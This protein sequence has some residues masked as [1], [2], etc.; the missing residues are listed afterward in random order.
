MRPKVSSLII[1]YH[2]QSPAAMQQRVDALLANGVDHVYFYDNSQPPFDC[3]FTD[4]Y[5]GKL[6]IISFN[7]NR[8]ISEAINYT[9]RLAKDLEF[10]FL[11]LFDQDSIVNN[12]NTLITLLDD[13]YSYD[14][15]SL[16]QP[17]LISP[18][19]YDTVSNQFKHPLS[20]KIKPITNISDATFEVGQVIS[21]G[22]LINLNLPLSDLLH[23][24][25]LFI[26]WVDIEFCHRLVS[27]K[28]TLLVSPRAVLEHSLGDRAT[29]I[30]GY[31]FPLRNPLRHY[32][33]IRNAI[34]LILYSDSISIPSKFIFS[35][36]LI[37]YFS[38]A[39]FSPRIRNIRAISLAINH[40]IFCR[41][42]P[43]NKN[44]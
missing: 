20:L 23:D 13:F 15:F 44:L 39:L 24:L 40:G 38:V 25:N 1:L 22:M 4:L 32:Y 14:N 28:Y 11:W 5:R 21:S 12:N 26:D 29:S 16:K 3:G 33:M 6:T 42:G 10:H 43:L 7:Q 31:I 18:L 9:L 34:Y 8:G 17:A 27:N 2:P 41:M 36:T 19:I 35:I 30:F 37:K